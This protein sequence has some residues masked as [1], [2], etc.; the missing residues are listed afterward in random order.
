MIRHTLILHR[1]LVEEKEFNGKDQVQ[2][3]EA[4]RPFA[5]TYNQPQEYV[6]NNM[7]LTEIKSKDKKYQ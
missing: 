7:K 4:N 1:V 2:H 5:T 3:S 6:E